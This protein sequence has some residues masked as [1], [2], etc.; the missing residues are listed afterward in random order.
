[1]TA[2]GVVRLPEGF[3]QVQVCVQKSSVKHRLMGVGAFVHPGQRLKPDLQVPR[4]YLTRNIHKQDV[5]TCTLHHAYAPEACMLLMPVAFAAGLTALCP[6]RRRLPGRL[7]SQPRSDAIK[8]LVKRVI[9]KVKH[10]ENEQVVKLA[11][12]LTLCAGQRYQL[13]TVVTYWNDVL[14]RAAFLT[15]PELLKCVQK[16]SIEVA[17]PATAVGM[18]SPAGVPTAS[19][20]GVAGAVASAVHG[21]EHVPVPPTRAVRATATSV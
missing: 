15:D 1:M 21:P 14:L 10:D 6:G 19:P 8:Q 4:R 20:A 18:V 13:V 5:R 7:P 3:A 9:V 11:P 2:D 16:T 17:S 12:I